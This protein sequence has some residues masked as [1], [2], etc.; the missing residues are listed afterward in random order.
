MRRS[1]L[2]VALVLL[3]SAATFAQHSGGGSSGGSSGG[4][5]GGS[6][7]GGGSS[8]SSGGS[9]GGH[10][11][12]GSGSSATSHSSGSSHSSNS[13]SSQSSAR[14]VS[15]ASASVARGTR[16]DGAKTA[17]PRRSFFSFLRH[18]FRRPEPKPVANLRRAICIGRCPVCPA[19][20]VA[21]GKGGCSGGGEFLASNH[22][23]SC[24]HA[25][26]WSGGA[27][28]SHTPF[29]DNCSGLQATLSQQASRMQAAEATRQSACTSG[30][31]QECSGMTTRYQSEASLY[32][33]L[34]ERYQ[35]CRQRRP[36]ASVGGSIRVNGP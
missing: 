1:G 10:S 13:S 14:G 4:G 26:I 21:N 19:G 16:G 12:G 22:A 5:G 33:A 30:S 24:S 25:E 8:S 11:S 17:A 18:P 23:H 3:F 9:S 20:Q 32:Q 7:G 27:C 28:L 31:S 6:H 15:G 34:Q 2:T 29:L 35:Q 36:T